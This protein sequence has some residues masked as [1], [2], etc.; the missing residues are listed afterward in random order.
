[1]M[2]ALSTAVVGGVAVIQALARHHTAT[3]RAREV[4]QALGM[5]RAQQTGAR[6]LSGLLPAVLATALAAIGAVAAAGIE[7]I[8]AVD[9]YEPHPGAAV[10]VTVLVVGLAVV[11]AGVLAATALTG[12]I[13]RSSPRRRRGA[14]ELRGRTASAASAGPRPPCWASGS[15]WKPAEARAPC[16]FARRSS[17]RRWASP[18]W[19]PAWCSSP[20]STA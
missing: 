8:G 4:E 12:A 7:P 1:M 11:F 20:A 10:N 16:R 3:A 5:T 6:L 15:R 2:L 14:R 17:A 9:L 18:A 13:A 19:W